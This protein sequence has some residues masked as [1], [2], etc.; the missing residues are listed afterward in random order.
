M[1]TTDDY[2]STLNARKK[3]RL[4]KVALEIFTQRSS[5]LTLDSSNVDINVE[6]QL[7]LK[8]AK[9]FIRCLDEE[10]K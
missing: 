1:G 7:S 10:V 4:E 8:L 2:R 3:D 9:E 6:I 5:K